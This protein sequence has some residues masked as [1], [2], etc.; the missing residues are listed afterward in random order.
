MKILVVGL[1]SMG[2]RRIRL[3]KKYN[4][5]FMIN[6]VDQNDERRSLVKKELD[7]DTYATLEDA[8][9]SEKFDCVFICTSPLSHSILINTC[10]N[11]GLHVFTELNLVDDG[12]EEN[13]KKA[14]ENNKVLFLSS[15]F[16]YRAE[17]LKINDMVKQQDKKLNYTYHVGQ[18][19]PDWHPWESYLDYFVGNKKT[20]GCRE[21]FAI[22]LPWISHVFGNIKDV[23]VNK[24][25]M[26]SLKLDYNDNYLLII[27]HVSGHK[28]VLVVDVISRKP[29]RNL[30][31]FGEDLYLSWDGSAEGLINYDFVQKKNVHIKLYEEVDRL[32]AY[33]SFIVENAY[34]SEISSFFDVI[35]YG[36]KP[37]YGFEDDKEVLTLIN[38]IEA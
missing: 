20:N 8:L 33:S 11:F 19:L 23:I 34:L 25:K 37:I 21:I 22:E 12:Y 2:R 31:I 9:N 35:K 10:L 29:V 16:L 27:E 30:E 38:R 28:G 32:D 26:S 15:T 17:I 6:G 14:K 4:E 7:I 36:N 24:S 3:I 5:S 18:Y 13:I 1:G